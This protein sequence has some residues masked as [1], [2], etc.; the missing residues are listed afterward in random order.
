MYIAVITMNV[1][2]RLF[3]ACRGLENCVLNNI[4]PFLRIIIVFSSNPLIQSREN[5]TSISGPYTWGKNDMLE[6]GSPV[7]SLLVQE[8]SLEELVSSVDFSNAV[9]ELQLRQPF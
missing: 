7:Q 5:G 9:K 4:D 3:Q 6:P 1:I 2:I 8:L